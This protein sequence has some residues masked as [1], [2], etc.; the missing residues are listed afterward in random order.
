M[1]ILYGL[2]L[3]LICSIANA[4]ITDFS[5]WTLVE[6]PP[7]ANFSA[8]Q[9]AAS[10]TLSAGG[11]IPAGVDIGFQSVNG[12]TVASST[13]GYFFDPSTDFSIAIDYD[14][15]FNSGAGVLG[16]GFG[17]GEDSDGMNS[18]GV[19]MATSN[20]S[21]FLTFGG[22]A[23]VNDN[24]QAPLVLG[25][26]TSTLS[27][28]LFVSY[29]AASGDVLLGAATTT[30]A[31]SPTVAGTYSGIQNQWNN[32][33]LLASF[34]IRSDGPAGAQWLGGDADAVFSNFRVLSGSAVAIPE[35]S[36]SVALGLVGV[37]VLIRRRR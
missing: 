4:A 33:A 24:D 7:N 34:F 10:A 28:S 27:G 1:R 26:A 8:T 16:L 15:T 37:W 21:P 29:E 17:I 11:P 13:G 30:G 2:A 18:A 12:T 22:A 20:G 5:T 36:S 19:A 32:E 3:T 14:W 6:D 31:A 23:R 25:T 35:P 9:T